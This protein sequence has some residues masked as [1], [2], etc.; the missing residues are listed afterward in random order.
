[1]KASTAI[2]LGRKATP[3]LPS[4]PPRSAVKNYVINQ[5]LHHHGRDYL[6]ELKWLLHE[7]GI[8]YDPQYLE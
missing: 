7:A 8:G 4:V 6:G 5:Q 3:R 1:M 2:S